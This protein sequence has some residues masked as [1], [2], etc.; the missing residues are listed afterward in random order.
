MCYFLCLALVG[1]IQVAASSA[2][3]YVSAVRNFLFVG[4]ACAVLIGQ[5]L[6]AVKFNLELALLVKFMYCLF[7][8]CDAVLLLSLQSISAVITDQLFN[9][10]CSVIRC[11][12]EISHV[13][14]VKM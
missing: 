13:I 5:L 7:M 11:L 14:A 3:R 8:F 4:S 6:G 12:L 1:T 9:L 10:I 2:Y